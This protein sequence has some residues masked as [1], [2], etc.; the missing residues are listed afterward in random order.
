MVKPLPVIAITCLT[1]LFA[2]SSAFSQCTIDSSYTSTGIYPDTLPDGMVSHP[3]S[4]DI[5]FVMPT[6]TQG[7]DFTNFHIVSMNLP[8]GLGW[9][10]DHYANGCNYDPQVSTYGCVNISG[11]PLLA[12]SYSITVNVI[13]DLTIVQ[14][15]PATFNIYMNVLA[16][17]STVS[18][19]GFTMM[20]S[21]SC[22]PAIVNFT[23]NNPGLVQYYWDFGNGNISYQEN[24]GPQ[25]YSNPG[26]YVVTYQAWT[27][28]TTY[29]FYDLTN[30]SI[31]NINCVWAWGCPTEIDPD[32]YVL[33]K[34]NGNT[35]YSSTKLSDVWTGSWNMTL[36]LNPANAY[37]I[38]VWDDDQPFSGDDYI[39]TYNFPNL[40]SCTGCAAGP[41]VIINYTIN[42]TIIPPTPAYTV[43]DT[44]HVYPFPGIPNVNYDSIT[45]VVSTDSTNY[46]LQW[47]Y[48]GSPISGATF[49]TDTVTMSGYYWVV[50]INNNGCATQSDSVLVVICDTAFVP[51]ISSS[52]F[53][54]WTTDSS[55]LYSFQW[56]NQSGPITGA[57]NPD[58]TAPANGQYYIVLTDQWGCVSQSPNITLTNGI[59]ETLLENSVMIY[60]NPTSGAFALDVGRQTTDA[61]QIT[62]YNVYGECV[63]STSDI[64]HQSSVIDLSFQSDVIYFL[65]VE[66]EG[67]IVNRKIVIH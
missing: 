24:P 67:A 19:S 39:G 11:T 6:D 16:D 14:G 59:D 58:Y 22:M 28:T 15:I 42:H 1:F 34:E 66:M 30:I 9:Q 17:T 8:V 32:P 21:S 37:A 4:T 12:G 64:G 33:L 50:A 5:T 46:F 41:D 40:N 20:G 57:T 43:Y 18:N 53:N 49:P 55:S 51:T 10:C 2:S 61:K 48:M 60:P 26:T 38:E 56:Y 63:Y 27:D 29:H 7:Y 65:R 35:I 36:A 44:V 54:I 47:Y 52:G 25:I 23:N 13:A 62:I 3:Y 45:N 31:T